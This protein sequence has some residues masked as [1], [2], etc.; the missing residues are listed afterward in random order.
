MR[1][2]WYMSRCKVQE[3]ET[4]KHG[5]FSNQLLNTFLQTLSREGGEA[6]RAYLRR[7][8]NSSSPANDL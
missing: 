5:Y 7:E 6:A 2:I 3:E 4:G 1:M 8:A